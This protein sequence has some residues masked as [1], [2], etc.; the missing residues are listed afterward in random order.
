VPG[1]AIA[2]SA[3]CAGRFPVG[4]DANQEVAK[5]Y[6]LRTTAIKPGLADVRGVT[7]DHDFI[8]RETHNAVR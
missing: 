1:G 7:I 5:S 8:E 6:D 2:D 3:C 4:S